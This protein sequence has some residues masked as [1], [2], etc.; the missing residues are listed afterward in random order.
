MLTTTEDRKTIQHTCTS[1]E[2]IFVRFRKR[3]K[4]YLS[5][6]D[7]KTQGMVLVVTLNNRV[8]ALLS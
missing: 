2:Y 3:E 8:H 6:E 5:S 7:G 4:L 1:L